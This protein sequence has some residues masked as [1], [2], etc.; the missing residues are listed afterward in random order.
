MPALVRAAGF[1]GF[2]GHKRR[3]YTACECSGLLAKAMH[4]Q[5]AEGVSLRYAA[6]RLGVSHSLLSKWS[7]RHSVLGDVAYRRKKSM[8]AGPLSQLKSIAEPLLRFI[9]EMREQGMSVNTLM[10]TIKASQLS[11]EFVV[12]MVTTRRSAVK[13]F[14]RAHSLVYQMG[15]HVA[16][17]D[18]EEVHGE[19]ID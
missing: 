19:A 17:R 2:S 4:M 6:S 10:V 15:M 13:W 14:L 7:R 5:V 18:P 16:Q 9:F 3:R 11:I 1:G 12:K 8:C